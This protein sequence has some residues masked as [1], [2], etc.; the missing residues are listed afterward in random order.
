MSKK[1]LVFGGTGFFGKKLVQKLID[2]G[3][4]VTICTR[5]EKNPF[6]NLVTHFRGDRSCVESIRALS[7]QNW[8]YIFDQLCYSSYDAQI[9]SQIFKDKV[10]RYILTST[11]SVYPF[12]V[13]EMGA[14]ED[15][16][17]PYKY[18]LV[19]GDSTQFNYGEGKRQAETF[20]FQ[21]KTF[22]LSAIRFPIVLGHGD[23]SHR[24]K[25]H[26]EKIKIG[27]KIFFPNIQASLSFITDEDAADALI[28]YADYHDSIYVNAHT[29]S[30]KLENMMGVIERVLG[31][32]GNFSFE[33]G[34]NHSPYGVEKSWS[35]NTGKA[36]KTGFLPKGNILELV[37]KIA[38]T[39]G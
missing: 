32:K 5:S 21:K 11:G 3:D 26:I 35:L 37:E 25:W 31:K 14:F 15:I 18:K 10:G 13:P 38:T 16:F 28:H 17:D 33:K 30:V 20:F 36:L 27:E 6:G 23:T 1:I 19:M 8:D 34:E 22:P 12:D 9:I 39:S 24:L 29:S 7:D 2:R 4:E